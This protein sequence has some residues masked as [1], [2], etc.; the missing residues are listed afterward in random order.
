M[1]NAFKWFMAGLIGVIFL[2]AWLNIG[3]SE[4]VI[5]PCSSSDT[6]VLLHGMA[7]SSR[8]MNKMEK[9][10]QA[11]GYTV[12][13][14]GYPSTTASIEDLTVQVFK[15][16]EP[17]IRDTETIH[18][19]THSMG[20]IMLRQHLQRHALPNLG[21]VVML[22]PPSR[23]SEVPDKLGHTSLYKWINGPAGNQLGTGTD[24][25]P[26]R[27]EAP[28]FELGIIAGDR[29]IN[30]I[31]S[32]LIPGPDDG[33]VSLARVKPARYTDYI[34]LHATHA[35]MMWNR[36]VIYQTRHFLKHGAF[37]QAEVLHE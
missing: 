28:E 16:L 36:A 35:C 33:K 24:S 3:A 12:I 29:S 23:G 25:I 21:R 4:S 5:T 26:L 31:L 13:N 15:T 32:M 22:A 8:S 30:P 19:V 20:G 1:K 37:Q 18:F 10:L 6:V 27:L 9:A 2:S 11:D 14:I 34:Q 17:H 7:R